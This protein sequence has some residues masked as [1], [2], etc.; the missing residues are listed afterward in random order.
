MFLQVPQEVIHLSLLPGSK[1]SGTSYNQAETSDE[2]IDRVINYHGIS[3][4]FKI[5]SLEDELFTALIED[6]KINNSEYSALY[7][8]RHWMIDYCHEH[9][10]LPANSDWPSVSITRALIEYINDV[11]TK[12]QEPSDSLGLYLFTI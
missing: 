5:F 2:T 8:F 6:D 12:T 1:L 7:T 3:L 11:H 9:V 4:P 10:N